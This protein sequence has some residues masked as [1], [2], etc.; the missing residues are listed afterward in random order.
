MVGVS[1]SQMHW[2]S[3][4]PPIQEEPHDQ[5]SSKST[6]PVPIVRCVVSPPAA[7]RARQRFGLH[8][9][10][11]LESNQIESTASEPIGT[12][13]DNSLPRECD[14]DSRTIAECICAEIY[15]TEVVYVRDLEKLLHHFFRPLTQFGVELGSMAALHTS[16]ETILR[17]HV[18]LLQQLTPS[19]VRCS[20][21]SETQDPLESGWYPD[22]LAMFRQ[23]SFAFAS[24]IDYMKV[25]AFYCASHK[26]AADELKRLQS[27]SPAVEAFVTELVNT[28][29]LEH[30]IDLFSLLIKPVQRICRYPLLFRELFTQISCPKEVA[31]VQPTLEKVEKVSAYVN[32]KVKEVE[33]NARLFQLHQ[34]IDS[35]TAK[36]DLLQPSRTL[37]CELVAYAIDMDAPHWPSFLLRLPLLRRRKRQDQHLAFDEGSR[38]S[39]LLA[40]RRPI[41]STSLLSP[42]KRS[43]LHQAR[44]GE[45]L[46][47]ILLSDVLLMAKTRAQKLKVRRQ[48]CLSCAI[49]KDCVSEE[50]S[51]SSVASCAFAL[52]VSKVGRCNCHNLTPSTLKRPPRQSLSRSDLLQTL[53]ARIHANKLQPR[54]S[55]LSD[56]NPFRSIKRYVVTTANEHERDQFMNALREAI[57]RAA[58]V[59]LEQ[60]NRDF[61]LSRKLWHFR[62]QADPPQTTAT[63]RS[64]SMGHGLTGESE[65]F[66]SPAL[67]NEHRSASMA[68]TLTRLFDPVSRLRHE[69]IV[70]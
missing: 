66:V 11:E 68:T 62:Q 57:A 35:R 53:H 60:K 29:K 17:I 16:V 63:R 23:I 28:M 67:T 30:Q 31:L 33:N 6:T 10:H 3:V 20:G 21:V 49:V 4:T 48:I 12:A 70:I 40:G 46:R 52:E 47:F 8:D 2:L 19:H 61:S 13:C 50:E 69:A 41:V 32:D 37:V 42:S 55:R 64:A 18:D 36:I 44:N 59:S 51:T 26:S 24:T 38:S 45:K 43:A 54:A 22:S 65:P 15:K 9:F 39:S 27:K 56:F 25:Y 1:P 5:E 58:R 14:R 7:P 34:Q